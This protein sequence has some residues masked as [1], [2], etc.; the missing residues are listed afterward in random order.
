MSFRLAACNAHRN[1]LVY[2]RLQISHETQ[3]WSQVSKMDSLKQAPVLFIADDMTSTHSFED[4]LRTHGINLLKASFKD[5]ILQ[6]LEKGAFPQAA[7]IEITSQKSNGDKAAQ[8]AF[9]VIDLL[10]QHA[11]RIQKNLPI[12]IITDN[13]SMSLAIE[14]MRHGAC[15]FLVRPI[16]PDRILK[17]IN[18]ATKDVHDLTSIDH[19]IAGRPPQ[20]HTPHSNSHSNFLHSSFG[21]ARP[22]ERSKRMSTQID[23]HTMPKSPDFRGFI[24][25][26]PIMQDLYDKIEHVAQSQAPVFITGESGTGKEVCAETIHRHSRRSQ[27]PF[28]PLNC[29]AIPHDLI[30]SELFG[31]VKGAFTG[32]INDRDGAVKL[33]H[34]GTLFLDE[35]AEMH[36]SMQ[37]KLL[38]FL[39]NQSFMKVGGSKIE[40]SDVRIICATNRDPLADIQAGRF[41]EDLYYRL[42]VLPL[43][44]P[45]LRERG[46]DVIDIA[47]ILIQRFNE[48]EGKHFNGLSD[49]ATMYLRHYNW[50][51]NI[52]QLQN[53][54]RNIVVMHDSNLIQKRHLPDIIT[55]YLPLTNQGGVES[56]A[57]HTQNG[58]S[59]DAPNGRNSYSTEQNSTQGRYGSNGRTIRP[60]HIVER[61]TI[62]EA[63]HICGGNIP[64]AAVMLGISPSTIY[65]KKLGWDQFDADNANTGAEQNFASL[66]H[67]PSSLN[68]LTEDSSRSR[69]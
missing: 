12:I 51:G 18:D 22:N 40:N 38:R 50:P 48:E 39:Q 45:P 32:A 34:G 66:A 49:E 3:L 30:E 57:G 13:G 60:L 16:S 37:S 11:Q 6:D 61:E 14:S 17:S 62:E 15:D 68:E 46:D 35:I 21:H 33:A 8:V 42:H 53:V 24:G 67:E 36:P 25:F 59:F 69:P 47:S 44:M 19:D 52:R 65:R 9:D 26:S 41:R 54:I 29:A 28:I 58:Y 23:A 2:L 56:L 64:R 63:I 31:H 43:H 20:S 4:D 1:S 10:S 7:F 5:N 55:H 27:R